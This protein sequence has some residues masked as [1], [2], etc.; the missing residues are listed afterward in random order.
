MGSAKQTGAHFKKSG[1]LH[2]VLLSRL[3]S[4]ERS[5]SSLLSNVRVTE[6]NI[7]RWGTSIH[8]YALL[9]RPRST[10]D[11]GPLG[12]D[13]T[14]LFFKGE[15]QETTGCTPTFLKGERL[16]VQRHQGGQVAKA[17]GHMEDKVT[18]RAGIR[19]H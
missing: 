11:V 9:H 7:Q 8:R 12:K 19:G 6:R 10:L 3:W 16:G 17:R 2:W 13:W 14:V 4:T 5:L 1:L 15:R 18:D